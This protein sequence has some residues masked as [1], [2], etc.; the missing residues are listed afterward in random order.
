MT[1]F[2]LGASAFRRHDVHQLGA[3]NDAQMA[4]KAE[5]AEKESPGG[6]I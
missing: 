2:H 3:M 1:K 4:E 6:L 5:E